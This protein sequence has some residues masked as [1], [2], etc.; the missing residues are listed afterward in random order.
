VPC[1]IRIVATVAVHCRH[2]GP[3][4]RPPL[5]GRCRWWKATDAH[6]MRY[7]SIQA[8]NA[9]SIGLVLQ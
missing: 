7:G 2:E 8:P 5:R 1:R 9:A 6:G 3:A 4:D